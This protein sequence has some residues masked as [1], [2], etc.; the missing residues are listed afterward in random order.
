MKRPD[1]SSVFL[2]LTLGAKVDNNIHFMD[3]KNIYYSGY[4]RRS[5]EFAR[6]Y[7]PDLSLP[8]RSQ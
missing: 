1:P 3:A 7:Y 2:R 5:I 6:P 8:D 4:V